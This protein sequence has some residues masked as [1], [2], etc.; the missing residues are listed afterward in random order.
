MSGGTPGDPAG[1]SPGDPR[2]EPGEPLAPG[3][4]LPG[5]VGLV[6][7]AREVQAAF[8]AAG[9][10]LATCESCTGGLVAH[11]LTEV[12]GSS[13]FFRGG[14]VCYSNDLKRDLAGVPQAVIEAHG[15]V[16]AQVAVAMAEGARSRLGADVAVAVTGIAGP[17]GGTPE[18]PVGTVYV[19]L[20]GP[21]GTEVVHRVWR[22]DRDR[23]RKTTAYEALDMLRRATRG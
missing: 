17:D 4:D 6:A 13:G 2:A 5:P 22:G 14:V 3:I 21:R 16:S 23:V 15:A 12:P 11:A 8:L 19:A 18:K 20:A 1:G 7:L 9:L 10:S